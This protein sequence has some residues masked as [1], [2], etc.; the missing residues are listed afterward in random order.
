MKEISMTAKSEKDF[1]DE[2]RALPWKKFSQNLYRLQ[3]R[4]YKAAK[5]KDKDLVQKLQSLL[6][7]SKC[8]KY[9]SVRLVTQLRMC[10]ETP[11]RDEKNSL[12]PRQRILITEELGLIET[13][14]HA[15]LRRVFIPKSN[16]KSRPLEILTIRDRAIQALVSYALEPTYEAMA[17]DGAYGFRLGHST[18]HVQ[19][20]MFRNLNKNVHGYNKTILQLDI[21]NCF[22]EIDHNKLMTLV[23]LPSAARKFICSALK[24]GILQQRDN[25][26]MG[27][28]QA[29]IISQLLRNIAL[30]G[31]EDLHNKDAYESKKRQRGVRYTDDIIFFLREGEPS[32]KLLLKVINFL[33][34]K[35]LSIQETKT[36]LVHSTEGFDFLGWHFK[37]KAKKGKFVCY[38]SRENI[39]TLK[40]N[41]RNRMK[42]TRYGLSDRLEK[43][44]TVYRRWWNYHQYCDMSQ[45]SNSIWALKKWSYKYIV[46]NSNMNGKEVAEYIKII[47]NGHVYNKNGGPTIKSSKSLFD[48]HLV[49]WSKMSGRLYTGPLLRAMKGNNSGVI[50]A[51]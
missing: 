39:R 19:C 31:V 5:K 18:R 15:Q 10:K 20:R 16:G 22:N 9:L 24:S 13:W 21:K 1:A 12:N 4:I 51:N 40:I 41:F 47:C 30:H 50:P 36:R 49:L 11:G 46:K 26:L 17:S 25:S 6:I 8:S 23:T 35:G 44:Q 33:V 7:G 37:V 32:G 2:W 14:K 42:D 29:A 45:V 34:N 43:L 38:P 3:H 28:P 48:R 27:N